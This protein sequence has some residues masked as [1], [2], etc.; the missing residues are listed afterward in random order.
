[1]PTA[2]AGA[3][4]TADAAAAVAFSAAAAALQSWQRAEEG[5][6]GVTHSSF[7]RLAI[8]NGVSKRPP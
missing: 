6:R 5:V 4:G 8:H 3:V 1:M 2:G 7:F